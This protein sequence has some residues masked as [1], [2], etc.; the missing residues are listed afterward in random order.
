MADEIY[1]ARLDEIVTELDSSIKDF[2]DASKIA[3]GIANS[4]GNPMGKGDLKDRVEDFENNW[5]DTRDD[6]VKNLEGVHTGLKDI[7]EGFEK[8]DL[9]TKKAFLNSRA[10]DAP[11]AAT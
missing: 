9:D 4:V 3:K 1:L 2:K 7:K 10:T 5:N 6:L 11:K 8:W